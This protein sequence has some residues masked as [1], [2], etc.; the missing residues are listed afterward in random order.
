MRVS[1]TPQSGLAPLEVAFRADATDPE[2]Q[3]ITYAWDFGDGTTGSAASPSTHT[4]A[5]AGYYLAEVTA[6]DGNG[7]TSSAQI[8]IAAASPGECLRTESGYC[9]SDLTGH[10][11]NDGISEEGD[12]D[13]GNFDDAGWV[14]AGDT[15]PPAGPVTYH[16]VPFEFPSYAAGRQEHGRGP[17]RRRCR[18]RAGAYEEIKLLASAHHGSPS[19]RRRRSTT[20]DGSSEQVRLRADGLGAV[21]GVRRAGGDRGQPPPR[22]GQRHRPAGEHLPADAAGRPERQLKSI[23]LPNERRIHL[24]SVALRQPMPVHDRGHAT[25]GD[26]ARRHRRRRRD[27]RR[28]AATTSS[29]AAA[30]TT[31]CAAATA[32]TA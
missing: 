14:F 6:T 27:L 13:D 11:N 32:T 30:A 3:G 9:V 12:F 24:F 4:Y 23:T 29:T 25:A 26:T 5:Q 17:R 16:G 31:C 18:S 20:S 19:A 1:A 2:G 8:E 21:A 28:S 15:M 22:P 10:Y 7:A